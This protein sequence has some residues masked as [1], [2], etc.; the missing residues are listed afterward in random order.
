MQEKLL[1]KI[2]DGNIDGGIFVLDK[3]VYNV[4]FGSTKGWDKT[5]RD[6]FSLCEK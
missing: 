5:Q 4:N 1:R 2:M 3:F 6:H